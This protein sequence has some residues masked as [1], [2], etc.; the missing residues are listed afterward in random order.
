MGLRNPYK[1]NDLGRFSITKQERNRYLFKV[2]S[3]RNIANT[4]PYFHDGKSKTLEDA[5]SQMTYLQMNIT[6]NKKYVNLIVTFL[7]S[8]SNLTPFE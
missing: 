2:H 7:N 1:T 3:L 6:L 8:L 5:V 4:A